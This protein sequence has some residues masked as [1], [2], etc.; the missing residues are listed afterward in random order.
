M[1]KSA[2]FNALEYALEGAAGT[3]G[4]IGGG[5]LAVK[6]GQ[7]LLKR[8]LDRDAKYDGMSTDLDYQSNTREANAIQDPSE[9]NATLTKLRRDY[10]DRKWQLDARRQAS[11]V[12]GKV[13]LGGLGAAAGYGIGKSLLN[14]GVDVAQKYSPSLGDAAKENLIGGYLNNFSRADFAN[15]IHGLLAKTGAAAG[16]LSGYQDA[17]KKYWE[18]RKEIEYISDPEE[19][20]NRLRD[21]DSFNSKLGRAGNALKTS[22]IRAGIGAGI[23]YVG[24]KTAG[25]LFGDR[26]QPQVQA[27]TNMNKKIR[28]SAN[29]ALPKLNLH[30]NVNLGAKIGAGLG[31]ASGLGIGESDRERENTDLG[32][33]LGKIV[34]KTAIGGG[35]GAAAGYGY[36]KYKDAKAFND[37][38]AAVKANVAPPVPDKSVQQARMDA[39]AQKWKVYE[40]RP[41]QEPPQ[42]SRWDKI[43]NYVT[44]KDVM[45][46]VLP[47]IRQGIRNTTGFEKTI[48]KSA[49]FQ[50]PATIQRLIQK[51]STYIPQDNTGVV[52]L[53]A[54]LKGKMQKKKLREPKVPASMGVKEIN[55]MIE[56]GKPTGKYFSKSVRKSAVF[57]QRGLKSAEFMGN[58]FQQTLLEQVGRKIS[59]PVGNY[60]RN[61]ASNARGGAVGGAVNGLLSRVPYLFQGA[62]AKAAKGNALQGVGDY[63]HSREGAERAAIGTGLVAGGGLLALGMAASRKPKVLEEEQYR[64]QQ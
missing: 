28:K 13:A 17:D 20:A 38:D 40:N 46:E 59:E 36:N 27:T 47:D 37:A 32:S 48:R 7:G 25:H 34:G 30:P 6:A 24:S 3:G 53:E 43:K 21:Y 52:S 15:P 57:Q 12:G 19:R 11:D 31:L 5:Y 62:K 63:L 60:F 45:K 14:R 51:G 8:K 1:R 26:P 35:L 10:D 42:P 2:D 29:F 16:A 54:T 41:P 64:T 61:A 49:N 9:R 33:R 22:A 58:P 18:G 50:D 56:S 23:G 39:Q 55:S 4:A 44:T